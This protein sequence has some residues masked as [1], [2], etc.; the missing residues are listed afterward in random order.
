MFLF[1]RCEFA[2]KYPSKALSKEEELELFSSIGGL[3]SLP[4]HA[5]D[6][7]GH[8]HT[9]DIRVKGNSGC[10][11]IDDDKS[12]DPLPLHLKQ[13]GV[14]LYWIRSVEDEI[15]AKLRDEEKKDSLLEQL[16]LETELL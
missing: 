11:L 7:V 3:C 5:I 4:W 10:V 14:H 9:L 16:S 8:G 13:E 15:F 6:C 1:A 12:A 2:V